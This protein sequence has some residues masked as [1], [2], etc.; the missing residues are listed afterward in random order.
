M[1]YAAMRLME[2]T[3]VCAMC[4]G[5]AVTVWDEENNCYRLAC[6]KDKT[7]NGFKRRPTATSLLAQGKLDE[8]AGHGAQ[9]DMEALAERMPERFNL[10]PKKDIE[11]GAVLSPDDVKAL[12]AF[13]QSVRLNVYLGHVGLYFG[14]PRV[15]IDG[16]YYLAKTQGRDI[17]VA[18]FPATPED[19]QQYQVPEGTRF[20]IARGWEN[21]RQVPGVG[22]GI[23]NADELTEMSKKT[24]IQHRYPIVAKYPERMAE[25]RAE[26]QLLRKLIPLEVKE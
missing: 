25:K 10:M 19:R 13:A 20:Y 17:A 1:E 14:E 15:T 5:E 21:G 26:W 9:K 7:H 6:G 24:P 12:D 16:Y 3:H 23:V 4:G 11:T 2:K 8:V 22:I 18:A